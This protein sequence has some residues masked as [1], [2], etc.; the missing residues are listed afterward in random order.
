M[1]MPEMTNE[2]HDTFTLASFGE[3]AIISKD[4]SINPMEIEEMKDLA[5][6]GYYATAA[7]HK[8][9]DLLSH[10]FFRSLYS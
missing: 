9:A 6:S 7:F 4:W 10:Y 3:I 8:I 1:E 2:E 5:T